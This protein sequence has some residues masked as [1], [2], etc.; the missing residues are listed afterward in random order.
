MKQGKQLFALEVILL[1]VLFGVTIHA[2]FVVYTGSLWPEIALEIK[3]WKELLLV[4]AGVLSLFLIHKNND[5]R[6]LLSDRLV[7]LALGFMALHL[8]LIP[9]TYTG[10]LP[11]VAGLMI[12]LRFI[13]F[14][15]LCL[16]AARYSKNFTI[17]AV[18]VVAAGALIVISFGLLQLTVLPDNVLSWYWL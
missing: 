2:P 8:I 3:A 15:L 14:M 12:D 5:W 6:T 11:T 1:T 9:F 10:L 7:Q 16:V 13:V 4:V 18:K 17:N